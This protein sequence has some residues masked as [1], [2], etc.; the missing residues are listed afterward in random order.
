MCAILCLIWITAAVEGQAPD[1]SSN[2]KDYV[3]PKLPKVDKK[4]WANLLLYYK[5]ARDIA[6]STLNELQSV[7]DFCWFSYRY[8]YA[9]ER[10]ANR[11]EIIWNNVKN[12]K[13]ENIED[14]VIYTEESVFQNSDA[15]FYYDIPKIKEERAKLD[16]S[17]DAIRDRTGNYLAQL[18]N[19]L[20]DGLRFKTK[21][22]RLMEIT[23]PD[24]RTMQNTGDKEVNFNVA[25]LSQASRQLAAADVNND[26]S[27]SQSAILESTIKNAD[28]DGTSDPLHQ[29]EYAKVGE[30]NSMILTLQENAQIAEAVKTGAFFLLSKAKAYANQ[31][32][33]KKALLCQLESFS[34]ALVLARQGIK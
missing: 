4:I 19:L 8:L 28:N 20:P 6:T 25:A 32:E 24:A 31:L 23:A 22:L 1:N 34:D 30:K 15:L 7:Q 2:A 33:S 26:F 16:L 5:H 12:F 13:A 9:I 17:R 11:A 21:Y 27:E 14:A 3:D 29:T 10:A 18:N